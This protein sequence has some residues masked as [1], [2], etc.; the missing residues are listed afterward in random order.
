MVYDDG[1]FD[2]AV[3]D[4]ISGRNA[5]PNQV[6]RMTIHTAA[7]TSADIYGPGRGPGETYAHFFNPSSN[8]IRQHQEI[9][10]KAYADGHA[11]GYVVAVEHQ[12]AGP[13]H[14]VPLTA[15]QIDDDARLFAHLVN[16][17]GLANRI[18]TVDNTHGLAWHRLGISGNF[19]AYNPN[20]RKTWSRAQTGQNWSDAQGKVCPWDERIDQI[21]DIYRAAQAYIDGADPVPPEEDDMP[22]E[23]SSG[24]T[25]NHPL[26]ADGEWYGLKIEPDEDPGS[27]F[28][29]VA[30]PA[31]VS[32]TLAVVV[33]T[34]KP[35]TEVDL[36]TLHVDVKSG[37]D[38][39]TEYTGFVQEQVTHG[40][41][42]QIVFPFTERVRAGEHGATRHLRFQIKAHGGG[43][44]LIADA[45]VRAL[46]WKG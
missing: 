17:F 13:S 36:R 35:D 44:V 42:T 5:L 23:V 11:N 24:Y 9:H 33:Q 10:H 22:T 19:G 38:P 29:L 34:E 45:R 41:T 30:G 40:G 2:W 43:E 14:G 37:S 18:A 46:V 15:K 21:D 8:R 12:D 28:T 16:H 27:A 32:G 3:W 26:P 4:P 25:P 39:A 1:R 20:D 6:L 7:T 31:L